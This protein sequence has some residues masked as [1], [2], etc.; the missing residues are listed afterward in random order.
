MVLSRRPARVVL[1]HRLDLPEKR[2][3]ELR[4]AARFASETGVL[5]QALRS[6]MD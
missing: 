3:P 5:Y 4:T 6:G 1:E 2:E